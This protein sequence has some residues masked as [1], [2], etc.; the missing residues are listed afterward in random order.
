VTSR[1]EFLMYDPNTGETKTRDAQG[2]ANYIA[3]RNAFVVKLGSG[4]DHKTHHTSH[5]H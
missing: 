2:F 5:K 1:G 4:A 3:S